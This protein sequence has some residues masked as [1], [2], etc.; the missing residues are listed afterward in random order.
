MREMKRSME[1][2]ADELSELK[3]W[4]RDNMDVPP[5]PEDKVED[6]RVTSHTISSVRKK[7]SLDQQELA[8]LLDVSPRT[9]SAWETGKSRPRG[10]N[11]ARIITL[12]EMNRSEV[13]E[14]LGR[15]S[16]EEKRFGQKDVKQLRDKLGL[17][18]EQMGEQLGVSS[19]AVGH[20]ESGKTNPG[21]AAQKTLRDLARRKP[22]QP[23]EAE[24][25]IG[26]KTGTDKQFDAENIRA[27]RKEAGLSQ[28]EM[29]A[30]LEISSRTVSNWETGSTSPTGKALEALREWSESCEEKTGEELTGD[31]IRTLRDE[32]DLTQK[33]FAERLG[34][35]ATTVGNWETG[36]TSHRGENRETLLELRSDPA[37]E[38]ATSEENAG[39]GN[40]SEE[41]SSPDSRIY[42]L[43]GY[44]S[45]DRSPEDADNRGGKP[46]GD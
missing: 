27:M 29:A 22:E 14:A 26:S 39:P 20:W 7:F 13:E 21:R 19:A 15:K 41:T 12:R 36:N 37:T 34:V 9:V 45:E 23:E 40:G 6:S 8:D 33:Q 3:E 32:M 5:A 43:R 31:D 44:I 38:D 16:A 10:G 35:T 17:T 2:M 42:S 24:E 1:K 28:K 46:A 25:E 30:E 11:K 4:R 18:Q